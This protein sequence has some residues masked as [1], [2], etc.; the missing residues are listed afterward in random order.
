MPYSKSS[1]DLAA[2]LLDLFPESVNIFDN[3]GSLPLR[4]LATKVKSTSSAYGEVDEEIRQKPEKILDL[5]LKAKPNATAD[6]LTALQAL[7]DW[8]KD[9]AVVTPSVQEV[10]NHKI[11]TRFPTAIILLDFVLYVTIIFYFSFCVP[12]SIQLRVL[13][14]QDLDGTSNSLQLESSYIRCT[15]PTDT[16]HY[17]YGLAGCSFYFL[18]RELAQILSL[19]SLGLF[20]TWV[21]DL[22]NWLDVVTI[23]SGL[24]FAGDMYTNNSDID[25]FRWMASITMLFYW[26]AMLSFLKS[27]F[28]EFSVFVGG[29]IN[30]LNRLLAFL[31]NLFIILTAFSVM[32]F[33][34]YFDSHMCTCEDEACG[35][36]YDRF[37][38]FC[39]YEDSILK[40]YTMLLGEVDEMNFLVNKKEEEFTQTLGVIT[41]SFFMFLVVILL[42]NVLIAI[43]TDSYGVIKNERAAIVFWS[44][45]L[46]FIAEMDAISYGPWKSKIDNLTLS[47]DII[48]ESFGYNMWK[49]LT[50]ELTMWDE[51]DVVSIEFFTYLFIRVIIFLFIVLL[52][53]PLGLLTA[54][55][56]W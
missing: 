2:F 33:I 34:I 55:I 18:L 49:Q 15:E 12:C 30:V 31:T 22:T 37:N 14:T 50:D 11:A 10:L 21:Y 1:P 26:V 13:K 25:R 51:R 45:R 41:F 44:N 20:R 42:A 17:I 53:L 56:L 24:Y 39:S 29:L 46:D 32:F 47:Q 40:V 35:P 7:P 52:W 43:V 9:R 23:G 48:Q 16:H 27:T 19:M 8:L 4:L 5:Y 6:F 36:D 38:H 3:H 54:G 28:I